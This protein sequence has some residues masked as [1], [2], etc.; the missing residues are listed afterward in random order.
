MKKI[1]CMLLT[2]AALVCTCACEPNQPE[3]TEFAPFTYRGMLISLDTDADVA[4][5]DLGDYLSFAETNSC[6]GDGKDKVYQYTSFKLQTYSQNGKDYVLSLEIFN[7]VDEGACTAEGIR[8]GD[9]ADDVVAHYGE[10]KTQT[11]TTIVYVNPD[12][13]TR[14]QFLLRDGVVTNIQYLKNE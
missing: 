3:G 2:L 9:T 14:L 5:G 4:L 11:A 6:Y 13:N 12:T 7:D 10:A 1:L 8:I